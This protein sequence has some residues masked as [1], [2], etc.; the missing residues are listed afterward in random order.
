MLKTLYPAMNW[1]RVDFYEGLPWY[2]SFV[3]PYVSAQAL[4]QFYSLSRFR[5]YLRKFDESRAQCLADIVH[6]AYHIMQAMSF[7]KGYGLGIF[8]GF[9]IYYI[10]VFI[11]HGYRNN[12]FEIPAY[13]QEYRFLDYCRKKHQH[14]IMPKVN[15]GALENISEEKDLVWRKFD[16][17]YEESKLLLAGSFLFCLLVSV[18]KPVIDLLVFLMKIPYNLSKGRSRTLRKKQ[19]RR[20]G[21]LYPH[22]RK[23]LLNQ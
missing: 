14:G 10:A 15:P 21:S 1:D 16:F 6:E 7:Y 4:P 23:E 2:T 12:P 9:T 3:A 11:R 17:K 19:L 20:K 5:I 13:N 8:R 18:V 22:M